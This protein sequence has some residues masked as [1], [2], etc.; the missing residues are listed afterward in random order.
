MDRIDPA[1]R[2]LISG[3]SYNFGA[4]F[5]GLIS[6]LLG[7]IGGIVGYTGLVLV[8]DLTT[9]VCLLS[10]FAVSITIKKKRESTSYLSGLSENTIK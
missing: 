1:V 2:G 3:I 4:L 6:V 10:V 7:V 5:G 9:L 8:I